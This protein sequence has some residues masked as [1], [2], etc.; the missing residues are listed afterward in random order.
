MGALILSLPCQQP[1]KQPTTPSY[2]EAFFQRHAIRTFCKSLTS[3]YKS[4][5]IRGIVIRCNH[6][7]PN[8]S[9]YEADPTPCP[10]PR[11]GITTLSQRASSLVDNDP[12]VTLPVQGI[13]RDGKPRRPRQKK[14]SIGWDPTVDIYD[15]TFA[16]QKLAQPAPQPQPQPQPLPSAPAQRSIEPRAALPKARCQSSRR[17]TLLGQPGQRVLLDASISENSDKSNAIARGSMADVHKRP[18]L[19][20]TIAEEPEQPQRITSKMANIKKEPR[21][22]TIFVPSEDT[23]IMTIHPGNNSRFQN[24]SPKK[25]RRSDVF[26]DLAT[27][28][29]EDLQPPRKTSAQYCPERKAPRKSLSVAPRRAPLQQ[30]TRPPQ[31]HATTTDVPGQGEGKENVPPGGLGAGKRLGKRASLVFPGKPLAQPTQTNRAA[32]ESLALNTIQ[33]STSPQLK[34]APGPV[35]NPPPGGSIAIPA[36]DTR[37][38]KLKQSDG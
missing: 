38:R 10:L 33:E 3:L 37:R 17:S 36:A 12:S 30:N 19:E 31:P 22:R 25:P 27:L 18:K 34:E 7:W 2:I 6:C 23:T 5:N 26:F 32:R 14:Q 8:M 13:L 21:R 35:T 1:C 9:A 24:D 16:M 20:E 11:V 29:E 15:D 4:T 28:G